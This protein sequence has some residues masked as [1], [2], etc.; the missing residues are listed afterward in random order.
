MVVVLIASTEDPAGLNIKNNLLEQATWNAIT[1]FNDQPVYQH[2]DMHDIYLVTI[3]GRT[4]RQ[5]NIDQTLKE[6]LNVA[7]TQ[8]IFITRHRAKTGEPTLTTHPV[9]NYATADYGGTP[10][11]LVPASPRLM[12]QLLRLIKKNK[13]QTTLP[14]QVCY[15]VTHH[16]PYLQTPTL[17]TEVGSTETEWHHK[18]PGAIIAQSLLELFSSY[19]TEADM[20]QDIPVLIGIGGGH[21]APRFTEIIFEKNVAFGHMIPSY[22]LK[23]DESDYLLFD[24]ALQ[25]TPNVCGVYLHR[26]SLKKAQIRLYKKWCEDQGIK[27][28]SSNELPL[29]HE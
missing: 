20:S 27:V 5:E 2:A 4:I 19:H 23:G 25:A 7:P 9:G 24:L 13:D 16:G 17:F 22:H 10:Q 1:V 15:E 28:F 6:K 29:L 26:K 21:Y 18:E 11:T 3:S 8:I 14:H 12:T